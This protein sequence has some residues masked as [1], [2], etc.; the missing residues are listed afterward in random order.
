MARIERERNFYLQN[1]K[2][3]ERSIKK[4]F[5]DKEGNKAFKLGREKNLGIYS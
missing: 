3:K 4:K 2:K 5:C 1:T